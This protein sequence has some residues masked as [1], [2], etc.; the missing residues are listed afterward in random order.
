MSNSIFTADKRD[1]DIGFSQFTTREL[2]AMRGR[3]Y[4]KNDVL[5]IRVIVKVDAV[6]N[7]APPPPTKDISTG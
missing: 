2:L 5:E 3:G 4:L 6:A 7:M 1:D